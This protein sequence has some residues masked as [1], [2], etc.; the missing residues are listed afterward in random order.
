MF[1]TTSLWLTLMSVPYLYYY[2][3]YHHHYF[4]SQANPMILG[5]LSSVDPRLLL[6]VFSFPFCLKGRG[7]E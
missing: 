7:L 3:H 4:N 5:H 6:S 2:Y 1:V